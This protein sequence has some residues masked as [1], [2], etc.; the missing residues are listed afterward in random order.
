MEFDVKTAATAMKSRTIDRCL[1]R[2]HI[3]AETVAKES[4][5]MKTTMADAYRATAESVRKSHTK[6]VRRIVITGL[7]TEPPG[8]GI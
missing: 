1:S 8:C 7:A 6:K 2:G 5:A 3:S 4:A